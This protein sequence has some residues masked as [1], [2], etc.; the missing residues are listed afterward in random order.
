MHLNDVALFSPDPRVRWDESR[1]WSI[2]RGWSKARINRVRL[3]IRE[4]QAQDIGEDDVD[5]IE[6]LPERF[7][8]RVGQ[9]GKYFALCGSLNSWMVFIGPSP[10]CSPSTSRK[11]NDLLDTAFHHR[12]PV[13]GRPHP[14]LYYPDGAGFFGEVRCLI[15]GA[16][17]S[18]G[19]FRKAADE[20]GALS[21]SLL[22]NLVK[23]PYA[24][25]SRIPMEEKIRGAERFWQ[26]VAPVV[27][28]RLI[29]SLTRT[30]GSVY[31]VLLSTAED[32]GMQTVEL[33]ATKFVS[34]KVYKLPKALIR[35]KTWGPVMVVTLPTH[36]SYLQDWVTKRKIQ[37]RSDVIKHL[38]ACV[39]EALAQA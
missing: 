26:T 22:L 30:E 16:Y 3:A 17:E 31:E 37:E 9:W 6:N 38:G 1:R 15:Q 8:D 14:T 29:V 7:R 32:L 27:R 34:G 35:P 10:G 25:E 36:P 12:N 2:E 13:L 23:K 20:F 33:P 24:R 4:N 39:K 28:P 21:N 19:H 18:A 5:P 11:L